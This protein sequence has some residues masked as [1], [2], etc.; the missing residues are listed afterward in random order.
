LWA[1][2]I[3]AVSSIPGPEIPGV[4]F[5]S[6]DKIAHFLEYLLLGI[7][8]IFAFRRRKVLLWGAGLGVFDELHQLF[9]PGRHCSVFDLAMNFLGLAVSPLVFVFLS[10]LSGRKQR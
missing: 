4:E 1:S 2:V 7:L 8:L 9:I 6:A 3:I 5:E 10:R